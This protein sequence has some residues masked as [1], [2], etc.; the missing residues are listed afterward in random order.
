[1]CM[2]L[3]ERLVT[4][5]KPHRCA[6]DGEAITVGDRVIYHVGMFEGTLDAWYMHP[7][8]LEALGRT[9]REWRTQGESCMG[10]DLYEQQRGQ[11]MA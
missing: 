3:Q 9:A 10:F 6:W 11:V 5:R 2:T 1:M 8:C 7:E 4:T